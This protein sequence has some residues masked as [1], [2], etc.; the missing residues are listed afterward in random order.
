MTIDVLVARGAADN[1][2][3]DIIDPLITSV[4]VALSRGQ[5]EIDRYAKGVPVTMQIRFRAGLELGQ[6]VEVIDALQGAAWRGKIIS[7]EH[8]VEGPVLATTLQVMRYA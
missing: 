4:P 3:E 2:G 6:T 8:G 5:V 7:I 1:Q